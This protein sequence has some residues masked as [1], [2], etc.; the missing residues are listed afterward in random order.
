MAHTRHEPLSWINFAVKL[1]DIGSHMKEGWFGG[2]KYQYVAGLSPDWAAIEKYIF[3]PD[4]RVSV[5]K[6]IAFSDIETVRR[7][8]DETITQWERGKAAILHDE[9]MSAEPTA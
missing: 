6:T 9:L 1:N 2:Q 4:L 3:Q 7:T 5:S 8:I